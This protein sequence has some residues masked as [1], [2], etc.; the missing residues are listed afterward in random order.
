MDDR[1]PDETNPASGLPVPELEDATSQRRRVLGRLLLKT[2]IV[3]VAVIVLVQMALDWLNGPVP[4]MSLLPDM[5]D[6]VEIVANEAEYTDGAGGSGGRVVVLRSSTLSPDEV[7]ALMVEAFDA[8]SEWHRSDDGLGGGLHV[9]WDRGRCQ[10][11]STSA[12]VWIAAA[13]EEVDI[14]QFDTLIV[15][16]ES[17]VVRIDELHHTFYIGTCEAGE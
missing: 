14:A 4:P 3:V 13:G 11:K 5:P 12:A 2:G 9:S 17:A 8:E 6:D 10:E 15:A 1:L 7:A 16:E